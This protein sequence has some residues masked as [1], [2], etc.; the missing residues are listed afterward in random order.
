MEHLVLRTDTTLRGLVAEMLRDPD[1]RDYELLYADRCEELGFSKMAE[2]IR[3]AG[4]NTDDYRYTYFNA[5]SSLT[6]LDNKEGLY[7]T[8][9]PH[10]G[11]LK[12]LVG[13][14][15]KDKDKEDLVRLVDALRQWLPI[16]MITVYDTRSF[17]N[18][19]SK[20]THSKNLLRE[21]FIEPQPPHRNNSLRYHYPIP[22][23][24]KAVFINGVS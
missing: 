17:A 22:M 12:E 15:T 9:K 23:L 2:E 24:S 6:K 1:D 20:V 16:I 21:E 7:Y 5:V 3:N 13:Y 14:V 11:M 4:P 18:A 10:R 19:L 8:M